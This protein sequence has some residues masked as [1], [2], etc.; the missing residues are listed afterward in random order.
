MD[1]P[2]RAQVYNN[3]KLR[4]TDDLLGIWQAHNTAEW[5]AEV[6]EMVYEIL[7]ERLGSLPE[8]TPPAPPPADLKQVDEYLRA[9]KLE[10]ALD[11]C[12]RAIE[13][14]PDMAAAYHARGRVY[15]Q[16][17]LP[18]Q[19]ILDDQEAC[20]LD[21]DL[22]S[23]WKN[24][25]RVEKTLESQ[26]ESSPAKQHLDQA[27]NYAYG[28]EPELAR[29]ECELARPMLP[30]IAKAYNYLGL[31]LETLG[32]Y[33][34]A[35]EAYLAAVR[36]NPRF[37]NARTNLA[38]ARI[39]LE[40]EHFGQFVALDESAPGGDDETGSGAGEMDDEYETADDGDTDADDT[41]GDDADTD[42]AGG[43]PGSDAGAA[44]DD[45]EPDDNLPAPG[46]LYLDETAV[47]LTG[48]LGHRIRP[49]RSGL[50]PLDNDFEL[51]HMEGLSI[52]WLATG[53]MRTH[54]PLYLVFM[55]CLGLL[56]SGLLLPL[57]AFFLQKDLF[58]LFGFIGYLPYGLIGVALLINVGLSLCTQPSQTAVETGSALY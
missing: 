35:E 2:L 19:A 49:G 16:M 7:I 36:L 48:W 37:A 4:D 45:D 29:E 20:R 13:Q 39:R 5:D 58:S 6:F 31:I 25:R 43:D 24:L 56:F 41:Q 17:H 57:G 50:D 54:Q 55:A 38:D 33:A 46:W 28:D 26:F 1:E 10:E 32:D 42:D 8:L 47:W 52:R 15:A 12:Q 18:E 11:L 22:E 34:S 51:A 44:E 3:L 21:P 14:T 40:H 27:P 53:H 23:A 30:G 9:G